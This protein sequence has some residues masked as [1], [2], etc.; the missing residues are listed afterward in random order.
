MNDATNRHDGGRP[1][2]RPA[3]AARVAWQLWAL[4]WLLLVLQAGDLASTYLAL[5]A[6]AREGN[7]ILRGVL[8]TP[9]IVVAKACA[10]LFLAALIVRSTTLG[11]PAPR[12]LLVGARVIAVAY[13]A[14][15]TNNLIVAARLR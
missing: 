6:G 7:V 9:G 13:L 8:Y 15:V 10:L 2:E 11:R 1:G 12:R 3:S 4:F 14:I 5:G